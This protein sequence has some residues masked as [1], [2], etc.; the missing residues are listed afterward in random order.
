MVDAKEILVDARNEKNETE[1][2][3]LINN[4]DESEKKQFRNFNFG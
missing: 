4:M 2:L 1:I 3:Q